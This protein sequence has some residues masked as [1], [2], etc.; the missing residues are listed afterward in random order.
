MI[1]TDHSSSAVA[2]SSGLSIEQVTDDIKYTTEA[3]NLADKCQKDGKPQLTQLKKIQLTNE[4]K[5][6]AFDVVLFESRM[7]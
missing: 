1:K 5:P 6:I 2:A 4:G 7:I 3:K